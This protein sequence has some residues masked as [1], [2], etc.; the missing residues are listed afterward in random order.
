[1][2]SM[3]AARLELS[4]RQGHFMVWDEHCH[5]E[6]E[7]F[8]EGKIGGELTAAENDVCCVNIHRGRSSQR[9]ALAAGHH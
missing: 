6:A 2:A 8:Q 3:V 7:R 9:W 1:M 4:G 5:G